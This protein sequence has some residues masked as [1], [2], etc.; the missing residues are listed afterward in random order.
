MLRAVYSRGIARPD[1]GQLVPYE[2]EDQT[3]S[4]VALA[5][6]NPSLKPEHANNYDLLY[7][8]TFIRSACCRPEASSSNSAL[9]KSY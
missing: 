2:T 1:P 7:E 5:I 3:A 4:P 8:D 9:R 6:G